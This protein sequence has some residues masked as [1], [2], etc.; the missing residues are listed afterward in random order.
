MNGNPLAYLPEIDDGD[1]DD[2]VPT[3]PTPFVKHTG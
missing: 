2:E 1:E 3:K